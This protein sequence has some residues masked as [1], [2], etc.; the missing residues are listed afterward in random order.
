[1]NHRENLRRA[2]RFQQP[3]WIPIASGLPWLD[4][5]AAGYDIAELE[6]I[7]A[8]HEFLF[9][10]FQP[11]TLRKNHEAVF[12][13]RPDLVKGNHYRDG[14]GCVWETLM[15]G[16][17]GSVTHH[18][19]A[20]WQALANFHAPDL[21]KSDGMLPLDWAKLRG[22]REEAHKSDSF[23][24]CWL[25]HGHTFLR[26]QDLR[27]YENLIMDMADGA[28]QLDELIRILTD[29]H[30]ALVRRFLELQPDMIGIPE[31][32]GMQTGPLL[33]P[34]LFRRYIAPAY[35]RLTRPIKQ[36]GIIVHEH[37]DGNILP[38]V[39]EIIRTGGDVLNLQDLVNG[40]D[41]IARHIKGRIAIDLDI[42]RQSVTVRGSPRDIDEHIRECVVKLDSPQ[43]GLSLSY[44]PWPPTPARNLDAVF[45]AMEK[46][47]HR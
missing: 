17:V 3:A 30:C 42:D 20:D 13:D 36:A 19:L 43:G 11:D 45:T 7:C 8:R 26:L 15:T 12:R 31:D 32:L 33:S 5:A 29:F 44:Q 21:E 1:M 9:P 27:G 18:P 2:Y 25:P 35:E 16:M 37:S 34:E 40:L 39:D 14:W 41:N 28:P 46:Y 10:N 47:C 38:L 6:S 22:W 23:F 4:W 24:T